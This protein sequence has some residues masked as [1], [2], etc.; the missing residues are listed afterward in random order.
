MLYGGAADGGGRAGPLRTLDCRR[1]RVAASIT[2]DEV[3]AKSLLVE[4]PREN[5]S[6]LEDGLYE[7]RARAEAQ[8]PGRG[9]LKL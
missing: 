1:P 3:G 8:V 6:G 7:H 9:G 4:E 2:V 5:S